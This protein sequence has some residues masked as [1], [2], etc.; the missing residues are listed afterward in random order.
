MTP[1]A[2]APPPRWPRQRASA[3]V[4]DAAIE[5]KPRSAAVERT[6]SFFM[7]LLRAGGLGRAT[8]SPAPGCARWVRE[9]AAPFLFSSL[10]GGDGAP[11]RLPRLGSARV[12]PA[13]GGME[14]DGSGGDGLVEPEQCL[15]L[16]VRTPC[17]S[18]H[19]RAAP[20]KALVW[21][22]PSDI[23]CEEVPDPKIEEPG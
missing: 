16:D 19:E 6:A 13:R 11:L 12:R 5:P 1:A 17:P 14:F 2:T 4:V 3:S 7:I 15:A 10:C 18:C 9:I 8:R 20:M 23:R 22:K 21:H